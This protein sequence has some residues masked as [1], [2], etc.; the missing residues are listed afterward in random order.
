M[1]C[2]IG[3]GRHLL[4][5]IE[6]KEFA[7]LVLTLHQQG[8]IAFRDRALQVALAPDT[9]GLFRNLSFDAPT[10]K[11][12]AREMQNWIA[13]QSEYLDEMVPFYKKL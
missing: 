7:A 4:P 10:A 6:S 2:A 8:Q 5:A 13:E 3:P 1:K 12:S 9:A 11:A